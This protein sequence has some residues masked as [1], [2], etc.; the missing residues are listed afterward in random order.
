MKKISIYF[1]FIVILLFLCSCS[2]NG[3]SN[4]AKIIID[5]NTGSFTS[6]EISSAINKVKKDFRNISGGEMKKI[7]FNND[8]SKK[9]IEN[10]FK[11]NNI[12]NDDKKDYIVIYGD[13]KVNDPGKNSGFSKNS[14]ISEYMWI[15]KKNIINNW[16]IIFS[17]T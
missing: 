13:F 2:K 6:E 12:N 10:Y 8:K 14:Y 17:G 15:M 7:S 9:E 1:L 16:K 11:E 3:V 5:K 4:D